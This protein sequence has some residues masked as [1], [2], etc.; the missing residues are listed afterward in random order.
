[1]EDKEYEATEMLPRG[2]PISHGF[3]ESPSLDELAQKQEVKP[4]SDIRELF[5]TWPG[6]VEDGFEEA[7]KELR[8]ASIARSEATCTVRHGVPLVTHNPNDFGGI[9]SLDILTANSSQGSFTM[10]N[11]SA[12]GRSLRWSLIISNWPSGQHFSKS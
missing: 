1:M 6:D 4:L 11:H 8:H 3:W 5:G 9:T 12:Q 10:R 7:I 2:T